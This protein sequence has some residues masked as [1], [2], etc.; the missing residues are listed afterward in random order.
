MSELSPATDPSLTAEVAWGE[1]LEAAWR[2][3]RDGQP[4]PR[5]HDFLPAPGRPCPAEQVVFLMQMDIEFRVQAGLPALLAEPYFRHP[6]LEQAGTRLDDA[7]Q[8]ELIRWEYQQRWKNGDRVA[9]ADYQAAFPEHAAALSDLRPHWSCPRCRRVACVAEEAIAES[10]ACPHCGSAFL[11]AEIFRPRG[12][13]DQATRLLKTEAAITAGRVDLV[14]PVVPGYEVLGELGR[15]GMGVVYQARQIKLN[16]LV[17]LKMILSGGHAGKQELARFRAEAEAVARLSHPNIVQIYEVSEQEGR[18]YFALEYVAGG[19]LDRRLRGAPLPAREAAG[20]VET[21]ARAMHHAHAHSLVHRDLKPANVLLANP[22]PPAPLPEAER[23]EQKGAA[24]PPLSASGRGVGEE[25]LGVPKITD[26]G[27][28]KRLDGASGPTQT[29][30]VLG[31]PSY[32]APEQASGVSRHIGPAADVYA[33]GAILYELLTGRPPFKAA[34][35][36]ETLRQ[37]L[38]EE[39]V[40]PARLQSRTPRDLETICLKCL[41]KEPAR[42]Y[43]SAEELAEDLRRFLAGEPI[44]AR[45]VG[46]LERT[47]RWCRRNPVLAVSG[48]VAAVAV[49]VGWLLWTAAERRQF[50]VEQRRLRQAEEHRSSLRSSTEANNTLALAELRADRFESAQNILQEA[51]RR[52]EKEPSLARQHADL[53]AR[54]ERVRLLA[55]F[56]RL[57]DEAERTVAQLPNTYVLEKGKDV[58]LRLFENALKQLGIL[59]HPHWQ[60]HLPEEDLTAEQRRHLRSEVYRQLILLAGVHARAGFAHFGSPKQAW[61]YRSALAAVAAARQ[62]RPQSFVARVLELFCRLG[63]GQYDR[64]KPLPGRTPQTAVGHYFTG[65]VHCHI[66]MLPDDLTTRVLLAQAK[67][68]GLDATT[69]LATA[70][71]HLRTAAGLQPRY[72]WTH[73]WLGTT[74]SLARNPQAAEL[75]YGACLGLRPDYA[76]GY[77]FRAQAI[78]DQLQTTTDPGRQGRLRD[79]ALVSL[80]EGIRLDQ[81]YAP[82][83]W[84]RSEV[85][86]SQGRYDRALADAGRALQL[87]PKQPRAYNAR[88][89]VLLIRKKYTEALADYS[90]AIRLEPR[91]A[92]YFFNRGY[93]Y[94][95]KGS[96]PQAVADLTEAIR[97]NPKFTLAYYWRSE[98]SHA[99]A[100]YDQAIADATRALQLDPHNAQAYYARGNS[101]WAQGKHDQ[102]I[103]DYTAALRIAPRVALYHANRGAAYFKA[104]KEYAKALADLNRAIR[105]DPKYTLAYCSRSEVYYQLRKYDEALAD[106]TRALQLDPHCA[107]AYNDRGNAWLGQDNYDRAIAD[108]TAALRIAPR[109][110]VY[111]FNRGGTYW[112]KGE[113]V[114]ALADLNRAIQLDPQHAQAHWGRS[115]VYYQQGKYD[116]AIADATRALQLDPKNAWAHNARG[117]CLSAQGKYDQALADY[118]RAVEIAPKASLPYQGR[119]RTLSRLGRHAEAVRDWDRAIELESGPSRTTLRLARARALGRAG[120][121]ARA[122]AEANALSREKNLPEATLYD[123]ARV[124]ALASAAARRDSRLPRSE[125]DKLAEQFAAGAVVFLGRARSAGYFQTGQHLDDLKTQAD[126]QSLRSRDDFHRL[127]A[128]LEKKG[129]PAAR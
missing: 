32:M 110:A 82:A 39:P 56:Y 14:A 70:E 103:A 5:W 61:R 74:L 47:W 87:D 29:G 129:K 115:E 13:A 48:T 51:V 49:V 20:L 65:L 118:T 105:L 33:L 89:N 98:A 43:G 63:L 10:L 127:L 83:Y 79:R 91:E 40:P 8:R 35:A 116:Q 77:Q 27:L 75:A 53:R 88:A 46:L 52:I 73:F 85:H 86:C 120:D 45:P 11:A 37:V 59:D 21:L 69:P 58:G 41:R 3:W 93:T 125:R 25:G 60:R 67:K 76:I 18:P 113:P 80:N 66:A 42:R 6:C 92:L 38:S 54:L 121:H 124:Y 22:S 78:L 17:A 9:R 1:P 101:W 108:F 71:E 50:A 55:R 109:T 34:T 23:G 97:L 106:A 19:S 15:G 62:Y 128:D 31:T 123:L 12:A 84:L 100:R 111:H 107:Q 26:F 90:A 102:A 81:K 117:N 119:A 114:K 95:T 4:P 104:R 126:L 30:A 96:F 36:M 72:Y 2:A 122:T 28:A 24:F 7:Q 99:Q 94:Y 57:A 16:R 44:K 112:K 68:I 64:V